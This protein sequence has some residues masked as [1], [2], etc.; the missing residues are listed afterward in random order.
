MLPSFVEERGDDNRHS[1]GDAPSTQTSLNLP[2]NTPRYET[3]SIECILLAA[4]I[5]PKQQR[6]ITPVVLLNWIDSK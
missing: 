6:D 3:K 5:G 2:R 4:T 1:M